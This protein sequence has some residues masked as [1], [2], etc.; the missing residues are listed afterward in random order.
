MCANPIPK[1]KAL[2]RVL[3]FAHGQLNA[4]TLRLF[5]FVRAAMVY[6][7]LG[8]HREEARVTA[9]E[10]DL[11]FQWKSLPRTINWKTVTQP[12]DV[13]FYIHRKSRH[14]QDLRWLDEVDQKTLG[15]LAGIE[16]V[17]IASLFEGLPR[18]SVASDS[19]RNTHHSVRDPHRWKR[20]LPSASNQ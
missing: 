19:I 17:G 7:L 20:P 14:R 16:Y 1:D 9:T 8:M 4:K 5:K 12:C 10:T 11:H 18:C 2:L 6:M 3:R 15:Q 13:G